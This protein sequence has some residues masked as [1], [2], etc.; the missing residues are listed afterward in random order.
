[1]LKQRK[2]NLVWVGDVSLF[3]RYIKNQNR[4]IKPNISSSRSSEDDYDVDNL[5]GWD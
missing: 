3:F 5:T 4:I 2:D 1:M